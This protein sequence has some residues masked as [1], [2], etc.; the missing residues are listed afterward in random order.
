MIGYSN[1]AKDATLELLAGMIDTVGI[2]TDEDELDDPGYERQPVEFGPPQGEGGMRVIE[3]VSEPVFS[4]G[5]DRSLDQWGGFDANGVLLVMVRL[6]EPRDF[7]RGD[8]AFFPP[9]NLSI[10]MP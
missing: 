4:I 10:G 5:R 9:G 7:V 2:F 1:A 6:A 8:R 3:N